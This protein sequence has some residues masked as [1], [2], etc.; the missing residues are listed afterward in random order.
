MW[1]ELF[2]PLGI[3][4]LMLLAIWWELLQVNKKLERMLRQNGVA[5]ATD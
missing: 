1:H 3:I 5:N 2:T 4:S